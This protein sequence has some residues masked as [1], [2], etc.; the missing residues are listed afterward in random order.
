MTDRRRVSVAHHELTEIDADRLEEWIDANYPNGRVQV[1]DLD[2]GE[3][4]YDEL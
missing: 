1:L 3:T 4:L 2:T